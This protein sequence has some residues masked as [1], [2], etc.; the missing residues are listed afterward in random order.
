MHI[1]LGEGPSAS[2]SPK[3]LQAV[4]RLLGVDNNAFTEYIVCPKCNAVFDYD[5]GFTIENGK[6]TPRRCPRIHYPNHPH[7][8]C[9]IPCGAYLMRGAKSRTG[10]E[11]SHTKFMSIN[12]LKQAVRNL[13]NRDGIL[14]QFEQC[15]KV[16]DESRPE[17]LLCDI[18]DGQV[19]KYFETE[20]GTH[21]LGSSFN[22]AFTL[23]TDWFQPFSRTRKKCVACM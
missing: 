3:T 11:L 10:K 19:W 5:N 20:E 22:V 18:Y 9:R 7:S 13:L 4:Y 6:R 12:H 16:Y 2:K 21:L 15:R 14:D 17:G 1:S 23:N 8:T